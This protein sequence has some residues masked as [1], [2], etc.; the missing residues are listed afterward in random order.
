MELEPAVAIVEDP[1]SKGLAAHLLRPFRTEQRIRELAIDGGHRRED[2]QAGRDGLVET[3]ASNPPATALKGS[4]FAVKDN[5][6]NIGNAVAALSAARYYL[7]LD[8][9]RNS[10]DILLTGGRSVP[11]LNPGLSSTGATSVTVPTTTLA[12]SYY[13]LACAD[14]KGAVPESNETN[15]CKASLTKVQV[16]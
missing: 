9:L 3:A 2:R 1:Q 13:L 15:N 14:D 16:P 8:T 7:S 11:S 5:V 10:G 12:G 6:Q 4:S